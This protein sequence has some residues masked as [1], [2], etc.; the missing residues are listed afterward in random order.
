MAPKEFK[1]RF[2]E[3]KFD[4]YFFKPTG[5][6][7]RNLEIIKLAHEELEAIRLIDVEHLNQQDAAILMKISRSTM[8]RVIDKAREKIGSALIN[9]FAI[10]IGG[11]NYQ[12]KPNCCRK[13]NR[14]HGL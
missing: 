6:P 8:Q 1:Q 13:R 12:I 14:R 10:E 7:I 2:I 11:G 3:K 5:I 9:G 4:G